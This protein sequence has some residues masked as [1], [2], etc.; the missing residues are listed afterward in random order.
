[1]TV[2]LARRLLS[3]ALIPAED[4]ED[5]LLETVERRTAFVSA[6]ASRVPRVTELLA[7]ELAHSGVAALSSADVDATLAE[8][9]P[10]GLCQRLLAF[11]SSQ[12]ASGI[13]AVACVDPSSKHVARELSHHLDA[14]VRLLRVSLA[15]FQSAVER[16]LDAEEARLGL[17]GHTP[18]FGTHVAEQRSTTPIRLTL[19][20]VAVRIAGTDVTELDDEP[21][22][23]APIPLVSVAPA[24]PRRRSGTSPGV[25]EA[26]RAELV[27]VEDDAGEPVIGLF[28]S[29]PP[30]PVRAAP[31]RAELEIL[32]APEEI[33]DAAL[34]ALLAASNLQQ[35]AEVL[36]EG[37]TSAA[38]R[39][40][41]LAVRDGRFEGRASSQSVDA[42]RARRLSVPARMAGV[43]DAALGSGQY[44]G[45][46][47][48]DA[49]HGPVAA[50]LGDGEVYLC[51]VRVFER[52]TLLLVLAGLRATFA[53]TQR[54]DRLALA[55]AR[56]LEEI[57]TRNKRSRR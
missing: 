18:A 3:S 39:T 17:G 55:A 31:P 6:L 20:P 10:A 15:T 14:P 47:P 48:A 5:A 2:E 38:E 8:R 26:R 9:L 54:A 22:A 30:P 44:L 19:P 46:L 11:P 42:E 28:R 1:M 52:P 41:V 37:C 35:V 36:A 51:V 25:G 4:V 33:V 27:T 53:A 40:L 24:A 23:S 57:V 7:Q 21:P 16:W 13:V 29:K 34:G 49:V 50:L 32:G 43:L 56:R 45:P 12:H